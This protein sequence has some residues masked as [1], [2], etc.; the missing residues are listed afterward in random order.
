[1]LKKLT[2]FVTV[3]QVCTV[4]AWADP[5]LFDGS[6]Q[7][8]NQ[9]LRLSGVESHTV[10]QDQHVPKTCYRD[11]TQGTRGECRPVTRQQCGVEQV[12]QCTD[13]TR[14]ECHPVQRQECHSI[15][16]NVCEPVSREECTAISRNVC[17][18]ESHQVCS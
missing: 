9:Q 6:P 11:E 12:S 3:I 8:Q 14:R 13:I 5:V 7:S 10:Y 18:P 2:L 1:M 17:E 4:P 16:R 15:D